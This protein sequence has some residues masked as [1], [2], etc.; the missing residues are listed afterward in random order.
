[1]KKKLIQSASNLIVMALA[2]VLTF[3]VFAC[4]KDGG[5]PEVPEGVDSSLLGTWV[6][7]EQRSSGVFTEKYSFYSD[8]SGFYSNSVGNS[9]D[10]KYN[11]TGTSIHMEMI[12]YGSGDVWRSTQN[13]SYSIQ[14]NKLTLKSTLDKKEFKKQ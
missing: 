1:M 7:E 5:E 8:K 9:A 4:S 13:Y 12:F 11:A 14:G 2:F 3:S 6:R 10:F